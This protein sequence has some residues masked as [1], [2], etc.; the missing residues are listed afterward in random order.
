MSYEYYI[1]LLLLLWRVALPYSFPFFRGHT[2]VGKRENQRCSDHY[3]RYLYDI[4]IISSQFLIRILLSLLRLNRI[5]P[6]LIGCQWNKYMHNMEKIQS[7][8]SGE[9]WHGLEVKKIRILKKTI[10]TV[11]IP[12]Y[13]VMGTRHRRAHGCSKRF[14]CAASEHFCWFWTVK[15]CHCSI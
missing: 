2:D 4:G 13:F 14:T 8:R 10:T 6:F 5:F 15:K 7:I 12:I 9:P 11:T 3:C 1:I